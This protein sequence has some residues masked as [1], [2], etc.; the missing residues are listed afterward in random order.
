MQKGEW[1]LKIKFKVSRT[2][3]LRKKSK[4]FPRITPTKLD[5][6]TP[7][8]IKMAFYFNVKILVL[9]NTVWIASK[10]GLY[11]DPTY[12]TF[13]LH[14]RLHIHVLNV[15]E[16]TIVIQCPYYYLELRFPQLGQVHKDLF[17]TNLTLQLLSNSYLRSVKLLAR[18]KRVG[19]GF[20]A[21]KFRLPN[22][23][24]SSSNSK[25]GPDKFSRPPHSFPCQ[26]KP[27][28][29]QFHSLYFTLFGTISQ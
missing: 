10:K 21:I 12:R 17:C 29:A 24:A 1:W 7:R 8:F 9:F 22:Q 28:R 26:T 14:H 6:M 15:N 13:T 23:A 16:W 20:T 11:N 4:F 25:V 3:T 19:G 18:S 27:V 2:K 5:S